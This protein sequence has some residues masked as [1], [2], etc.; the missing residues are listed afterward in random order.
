MVPENFENL[1]I[2]SWAAVGTLAFVAA[3]LAMVI[4]K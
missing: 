4:M 2:W 1:F 3:V